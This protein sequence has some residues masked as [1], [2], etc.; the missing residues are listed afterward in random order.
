MEGAEPGLDVATSAPP[1][2]CDAIDQVWSVPAQITHRTP[3]LLALA[4]VC[5]ALYPVETTGMA[6]GIALYEALLRLGLEQR[7]I[8]PVAPPLVAISL[9]RAI[10]AQSA[11]RW[12]YCPLDSAGEIPPLAFGPNVV[13]RFRP[14]D[15]TRLMA[16]LPLDPHFRARFDIERMSQFQWLVVEE[17]YELPRTVAERYLPLLFKS[18]NNELGSIEPHPSHFTPAVEAAVSFLLAAPWEEFVEKPSRD[19]RGF[20][21]PWV[22]TLDS[23]LFAPSIAVPDPKTLSWIQ[24]YREDDRGAIIEEVEF[25]DNI[26]LVEGAATKLSSLDHRAWTRFLMARSSP[27]MADPIIHFFV[28]AFTSRDIDEFLFH[29]T[30]IEA[31]LGQS[32]DHQDKKRK[33][34][35]GTT[36][37]TARTAWRLSAL[38]DDWKA[39]PEF[40]RIFKERSQ[41]VHG[42]SMTAISATS[43]VAARSLAR[44]CVSALIDQAPTNPTTREDFM[45]ALIERQPPP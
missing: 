36:G 3:E 14:A 27:V 42:E 11:V 22:L 30:T 33:L 10:R 40:K 16:S 24:H 15:L 38:L 37:A 43:I 23:D 45:E 28:R 9:D 18:W 35:D 13:R 17:P 4:K 32:K 25:P 39:G 29:I 19:W 7:T 5:R 26:I 41:F 2:L 21:I 34:P 31:C 1:R 20:R 44:R 8:G 12:H 6:L